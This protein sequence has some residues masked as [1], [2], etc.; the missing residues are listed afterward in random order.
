MACSLQLVDLLHG[1]VYPAQQSCIKF[2]GASNT[3]HLCCIKHGKETG[4]T[5][6]TTMTSKQF[7]VFFHFG[8][9]VEGFASF[10]AT[11]HMPVSPGEQNGIMT[12][13]ELQWA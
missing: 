2:Q 8:D 6:A 12:K 5:P 13:Q 11:L 7:S 3:L 1:V 9:A 4:A 10:S